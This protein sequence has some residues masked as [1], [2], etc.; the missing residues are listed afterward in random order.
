MVLDI[1]YK[2]IYMIGFES[3][4]KYISEKMKS[5]DMQAAVKNKYEKGDGP[6]KI[7]RHLGG[8]VSLPTIK[9]VD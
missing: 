1:L 4:F 5:K 9:F 8:V 3:H 6:T 7:Y 2:D